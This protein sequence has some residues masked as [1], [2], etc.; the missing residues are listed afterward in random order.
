[1]MLGRTVG[2]AL[3]LLA[4][5][6]TAGPLTIGQ[7]AGA[8]A[9]AGPQ[10]ANERDGLYPY[11]FDVAAPN[12]TVAW[13]NG[14]FEA[15]HASCIPGA[16]GRFIC[17]DAIS[18]AELVTGQ[19]VGNGSF[20]LIGVQDHVPI[21]IPVRLEAT[22][23]YQAETTGKLGLFLHTP[24]AD[25][26]EENKTR[27]T[28]DEGT[29]IQLASQLTRF[30]DGG[31][32]LQV[33]S[34]RP[35]PPSG[36][37]Y[38]LRVQIDLLVDR[39]PAGVVVG[40][41]VGP[42]QTVL[43]EPAE[44]NTPGPVL[45]WGPDDTYL[46]RTSLE[47]AQGPRPI[48]PAGGS[49]EF[50][51][52]PIG[53][54]GTI[55]L[56][57]RDRP[58]EGSLRLFPV[59]TFQGQPH[60]LGPEGE[61][62][63]TFE[64]D[65]MPLQ[66]GLFAQ[67]NR[68]AAMFQPSGT[69]DSETGRVLGFSEERKVYGGGG[70]FS[71][72]F[73]FAT[74][75]SPVGHP[76]LTAGT[77]DARFL[78]EADL[79]VDVGHL[80]SGYVRPPP[81][82]AAAAAGLDDTG[83]VRNPP[84]YLIARETGQT[85]ASQL[86]V[87][88]AR[89]AAV[90]PEEARLALGVVDLSDIEI[91]PGWDGIVY[92]TA[93]ETGQGAVMAG[94]LITDQGQGFFCAQDTL[95][96]ED[97]PRDP[98]SVVRPTIEGAFVPNAGSGERAGTSEDQLVFFLEPDCIG[99]AH[100]AVEVGQVGGGSF[101]LRDTAQGTDVA[102]TDR[103]AADAN[104]SLFEPEPTGAQEGQSENTSDQPVAL[105]GGDGEGS[106]SPSAGSQDGDGGIPAAIASLSPWWLVAGLPLLVLIGA[107]AVLARAR[108]DDEQE[109]RRPTPGR[110]FLGKYLVRRKL[111]QGA[112]GTV[113]LAEHRHLEREAVIKQLHPQLARDRQARKRFEREAKL[114]AQL[115]HPNVTTVYDVELVDG[116][117][118]LVMEHV[119][120]GSLARVEDA[121][122]LPLDA[123][124]AAIEEMLQ[125]LA[126]VHDQGIVHRDLKPSN[127]LVTSEG[128]VK[129]A[130][131]GIARPSG[132]QATALTQTGS[133]PGT[134]HYMAPEQL[135]GHRG[136]EK[137]DVYAAAVV[138][139]TLLTGAYYLGQPPTGFAELRRRI[140]EQG[141]RLPVRGLPEPVNDWLAHGLA[142]DPDQRFQSA[143]TMRRAL[144]EA[145]ETG[146]VPSSR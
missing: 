103:V 81:R 38:T 119:A 127:L 34:D 136:D 145:V 53:P 123:A 89:A 3:L 125:G 73:V 144:Q 67:S 35:D 65:H 126:Y 52:A 79:G 83:D 25:T 110:P 41:P 107:A 47:D 20:R 88:V 142:Q 48:I 46:G 16:D 36:L 49:G 77:Y 138:S 109:I 116:V 102:A 26:Y 146:D 86:D 132:T 68:T 40:V 118:Y 11:R 54:K 94:L 23:S 61:A 93:I 124:I 17:I 139:Y 33:I 5:S 4:L 45:T 99:E 7:D 115:D 66:I 44:E 58:P 14:S 27:N 95:V 101:L 29:T 106:R 78:A 62:S 8:Q 105:S 143:R 10:T 50:A 55:Q 31:V 141:P 131:F 69:I 75:T 129:L 96:F 111:G 30:E 122:A 100:G 12:Q 80:I 6:L 51:V 60:A 134:P 91:P 137:S 113:W 114:L 84:T 98:N 28:G 71:H 133:P 104:L 130:D 32:I 74:W 64:V 39:I 1:M 128:T 117:W 76:N 43:A 19:E 87:T 2:V 140:R 59:G 24:E 42:N 90:G 57:S 92:A 72:P 37:D 121:G 82:G 9:E 22:L 70:T 135:A 15:Y 18:G 112:F 56:L 97:R 21:G 120:G 13:Y 63:W 85:D 108:E